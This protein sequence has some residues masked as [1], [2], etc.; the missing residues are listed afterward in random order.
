MHPTVVFFDLLS[1]H[2]I[3]QKT[4]YLQLKRKRFW[5]VGAVTFPICAPVL[6]FFHCDVIRGGMDQLMSFFFVWKRS[7]KGEGKGGKRE[8]GG[9]GKKKEVTKDTFSKRNCSRIGEKRRKASRK[10][11][12]KTRKSRA[13]KRK[14]ETP[15]E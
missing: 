8:D 5:A 4:F 15:Y 10:N 6:V 12:K 3:Y 2:K 9:K 7:G 11:T 14:R 1:Y 13:Y